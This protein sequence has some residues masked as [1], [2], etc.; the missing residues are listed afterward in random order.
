MQSNFAE[1]LAITLA[2]EGGY[3]TVKSDPG[4]WTGGKVGSGVLKGTKY[5][6]AA[7][8]HPDLDIKNLTLDDAGKIY[9]PQY[10]D[11]VSGD[12]LASGVDL[13]TWD[14]AVNSGPSRALKA[15]LA[16]VGGTDVQTVKK[17]CAKRLGFL[18]SLAIWK[19][20][21]GGWSSRVAS[22][23][24]KG[25]AWAL[26][27]VKG[28]A[29]VQAGLLEEQVAAKKTATRNTAAAGTTG[30]ATTAGGGDV[31]LNPQHADQLAGWVLGGLL[32]V[33][34]IIVL[35][36]IVRTIIHKQRAD[37]YAIEAAAV[38]WSASYDEKGG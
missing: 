26:A 37:A 21:K 11:K 2:Y 35:V 17:I 14:Y 34:A 10:W 25:V 28:P 23:E 19:T 6:I 30:A 5:G 27:A 32:G 12:R 38:R 31:A 13:V 20:F 3:S 9:K 18:Q 7:S 1:A 4:N 29:A 16:S 15:L 36:L 8:A 33:A 22:V 24:A